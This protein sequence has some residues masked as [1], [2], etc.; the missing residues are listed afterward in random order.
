MQPRYAASGH[1]IYAQGGTLMAATFDPRRL[2]IMG[3][4]VPMVEGVAYS[5]A[6]A[7]SQYS[8]SDNGI[9][10]LR[11]GW[12]SGKSTADRVG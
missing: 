4:P 8:I 2:E 6:L 12:D 3:T 10:G 7:S 1:L 5:L 9:I 11:F